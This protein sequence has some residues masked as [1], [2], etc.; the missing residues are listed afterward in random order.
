MNSSEISFLVFGIVL[1][2]AL[3]IDLGLLSKKTVE[4]NMKNA[5]VMTIFWVILSLSFCLFLWLEKGEEIAIQFLSGYTM[6]WSLSADNIF[7]FILIFSFFSIR[8]KKVSRVLLAGVLMAIVFRVIFIGLGM[9]LVR[10]FHW[11]LYLFGGFLIFT[12]IKMLLSNPQ[13]SFHPEKSG[14]LRLMKKFFRFTDEDPEGR[15]II[16]KNKRAFFTKLFLVMVLIAITD[17]IFAMDS[18]PAVLAISRNALVVYTSNIFA[19]LGLRSLFFLLKESVKKFYFLPYGIA[20][21]L[22]FIGFKM[23]IEIFN[24]HL[25]TLFSLMM[26]IV[27]LS[28]SVIFS[29]LY[30][31]R[32]LPKVP[33]G[34]PRN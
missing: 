1:V 25:S 22:I 34:K 11:I 15:M 27:F 17:I 16:W 10:H 24:H 26:I 31:T 8:E 28:G 3:F 19:V 21:V 18:I 14:V 29:L 6:E 20:L 32:D 33:F 4:M 5:W 12:G 2:V 9:S 7:I 30:P 23:L 13:K